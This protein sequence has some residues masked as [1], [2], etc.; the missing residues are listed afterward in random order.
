[1]IEIKLYIVNAREYN[2]GI[3][4]AE[5]I[6]LPTDGEEI[7]EVINRVTNN[8]EN[9]FLIP[10]YECKA[11]LNSVYFDWTS[12][13]PCRLNTILQEL[14]ELQEER[15]LSDEELVA[16]IEYAGWFDGAFENLEN[17][18]YM[19]VPLERG[20]MEELAE[21]LV[22]EYGWYEIPSNVL[23]FIDWGLVADEI[24]SNC[25]DVYIAN[26]NIAIVSLD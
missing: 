5:A 4:K 17:Y 7:E 2:E 21:K 18:E 19:F 1:M 24:Q 16:M 15:G 3:W 14:S 22:T 9:D 6:T 8:R 25:S 11:Y 12:F 20:T 13:D 26:N 23:R 10:D